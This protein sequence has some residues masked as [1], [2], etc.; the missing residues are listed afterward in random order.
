[1]PLYLPPREASTG[2]ACWLWPLPSTVPSY[3][4]VTCSGDDCVSLQSLLFPSPLLSNA[5]APTNPVS[6]QWFSTVWMQ[7]PFNTLPHVVLTPNHEII[8]LLLHNCNFATVMNSNVN[9]W[10]AGCL[11]CDPQRGHDPR[12][13]NQSHSVSVI[14]PHHHKESSG[15][16]LF[17]ALIFSS[18]CYTK[19][20]MIRGKG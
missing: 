20:Q 5:S 9:I 6:E 12:A 2:S 15:C 7:R 19:P 4:L 11:I 18:F 14:H 3:L 13:E 16:F 17:S 8:L 1:M 10:L